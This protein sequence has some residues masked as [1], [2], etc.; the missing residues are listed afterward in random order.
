MFKVKK[1]TTLVSLLII[2]SIAGLSGVAEGAGK[3]PVASVKSVA[4]PEASI[5]G[6]VK[7]IAD[8]FLGEELVYRISFW[9]FKNVA[10]GKVLFK[11][12]PESDGY[13]AIMNAYTTGAVAR[14]VQKR[15][16]YYVARLKLSE[17]GTRFM[18]TSLTKTVTRNGRIKESRTYV[19]HENRIVSW[20]RWGDGREEKSGAV[21][22]EEGLFPD[23]PLGA[24]YNFRAEA[25][26]PLKVGGEYKIT[27]FPKIDH[28]PEIILNI[29]T[30]EQMLKRL[31]G[32]DAPA[33]YLAD[34]MIGK[35]FFGSGKGDIEIYFSKGLVPLYAV[36]KD[37]AIFGDVKGKLLGPGDEAPAE[38]PV[39]QPKTEPSIGIDDDFWYD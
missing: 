18:T 4:A 17:D 21:G 30:K 19:D 29:A 22:F 5:D 14:V 7:T 3:A 2:V 20:I 11:E 13:L 33:E 9:F 15:H 27:T 24:F 25:Y 28:V 10:I 36:A 32:K 39:E 35:E 23:D 38:E 26:G 1:I 6:K 34:A 16:D 31:K 8:Q 12:D 37:V